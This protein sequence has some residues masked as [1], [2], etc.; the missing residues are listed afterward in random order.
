MPLP[1]AVRPLS[2]PHHWTWWTSPSTGGAL[3]PGY[4]QRRS[5]A[6]RTARTSSWWGLAAPPVRPARQG[7]GPRAH[8]PYVSADRHGL[9]AELPRAAVDP[10][11]HG[12][13]GGRPVADLGTSPAPATRRPSR[14]CNVT[15]RMALLTSRQGRRQRPTSPP[16]PCL[17]Y[18]S[19]SPRDGLLS[20]MPS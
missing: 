11:R 3:Q 8:T 18:T 12:L 1:T 16:T 17:L 14:S 20:R 9:H 7:S 5:R 6:M 2:R 10:D 4:W 13:P 15:F 19:P